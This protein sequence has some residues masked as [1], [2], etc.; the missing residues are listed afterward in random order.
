MKVLVT[1]ASGFLGSHICATLVEEGCEVV[2]ASRGKGFLSEIPQV[3]WRYLNLTEPSSF[4]DIDFSEFDAVVHNAGITFTTNSSRYL[5]VNFIGTRLLVH[6]LQE[7]GFRGKFLYISSLAVHGPGKAKEE[8][9]LLMPITPYGVS[10]LLGEQEVRASSLDWLVL[11]PPV[12]F[13]ERDNALL[14]VYRLLAKGIIF[15]W[16]PEKYLSLCYAKNV[17]KA[18]YFLLSS[19]FSKEIFLIKDATL[20]WR[21][22]GER[23]HSILGVD[24][25]FVVPLR[26]W[27]VELLK[28]VAGF[29]RLAFRVPVDKYKLEEIMAQ[30]WIVASQKLE[31]AGFVPAYRFDEALYSTL[32]WCKIKKQ[33]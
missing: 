9:L 33:L 11:R 15:Q 25:K 14:G 10:K 8:D 4:E 24:R 5:T 21:E 3:D 12:I 32:E 31:D 2:G 7:V 23:V 29:L 18:V 26:N 27:M 20:S 28:P 30:E 13:G 6:R 1:G 16:K 17:A 19:D 22:F